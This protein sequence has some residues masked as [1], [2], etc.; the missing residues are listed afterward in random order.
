MLP[1]RTKGYHSMD[2]LP[3]WG[4]LVVA[5]AVLL[6]PV[7]AFFAAISVEMLVCMMKEGG[8]PALVPLAAACVIGRLLYRRFWARGRDGHLAGGHA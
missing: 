6:S 7:F 5:A 1:V 3:N 2:R 4:W 8:A